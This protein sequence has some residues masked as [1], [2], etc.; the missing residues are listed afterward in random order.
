MTNSDS[1]L[2]A[3]NSDE[4]Q[5]VTINVLYISLSSFFPLI[6]SAI[7]TLSLTPIPTLPHTDI[8]LQITSDASPSFASVMLHLPL[9]TLCLCTSDTLPSY[10]WQRFTFLRI[11]DTLPPLRAG[12]C[13]P[14]VRV[15][16]TSPRL[17]IGNHS[18]FLHH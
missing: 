2:K 13:S 5:V 1:L 8:G 3:S 16:D 14:L 17:R 9:A 4:T 7:P 15:D 6:H 18:L 12:N 10:A 11:D